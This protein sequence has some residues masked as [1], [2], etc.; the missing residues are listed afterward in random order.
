MKQWAVNG[1]FWSALT[2]QRFGSSRPV[3]TIRGLKIPNAQG[4]KPPW[5]KALTG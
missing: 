1:Q 3:A 4:V 2:G 5:S